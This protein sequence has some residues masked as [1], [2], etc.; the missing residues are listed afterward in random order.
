M[1]KK[2]TTQAEL[3][4]WNKRIKRAAASERALG[5]EENAQHYELLKIT[6]DKYRDYVAGEGGKNLQRTIKRLISSPSSKGNKLKET[7][8]NKAGVALPKVTATLIEAMDKKA[9]QQSAK[10]A[11]EFRRSLLEAG[12]PVPDPT[13]AEKRVMAKDYYKFRKSTTRASLDKMLKTIINK[14]GEKSYIDTEANEAKRRYIKSL[15][16]VF[17]VTSRFGGQLAD[18]NGN[19]EKLDELKKKVKEM[20][21]DKFLKTFTMAGKSRNKDITIASAYDSGDNTTEN[22][23]GKFN[24]LLDNWEQ[25]LQVN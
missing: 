25:V 5:H 3:D 9:T 6:A 11:K 2:G 21:N 22:I 23:E 19:N 15:D 20:D 13:Q 10:R 1:A 16:T 24:Q 18:D 4:A 7:V 14:A 12:E 8:T 17:G